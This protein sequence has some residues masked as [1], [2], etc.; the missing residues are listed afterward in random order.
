MDSYTIVRDTSV[1]SAPIENTSILGQTTCKDTFE[2]I[3]STRTRT[4]RCFEKF[5]RRD[6]RGVT[7]AEEGELEVVRF[8]IESCDRECMACR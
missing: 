1:P 3:M 2:Y 5:S 4:I 6:R 8:Q 7:E